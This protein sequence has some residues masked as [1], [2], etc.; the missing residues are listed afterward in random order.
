[1]ANTRKS[2]EELRSSAPG[3]AEQSSTANP[4]GLYVHPASGAKAI[5]LYHPKFGAAQAD[6][7]V[8][9]GFEWVR[10]ATPGELVGPG[11]GNVTGESVVTDSQSMGVEIRPDAVSRTEMEDLQAAMKKQQEE[12][13][14]YRKASNGDG[15][16]S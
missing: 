9:V 5:A 14:A 12:F 6:G 11:F 2:T 7:L 10:D 1:M 8:R 15:T 16:N 3:E 13:E 4:A